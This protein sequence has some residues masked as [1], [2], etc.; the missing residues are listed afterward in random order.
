MYCALLG[1][2]ITLQSDKVLYVVTEPVIPLETYIQVNE[3][4]TGQNELAI[5]WG[6]HQITVS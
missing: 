6:L 1:H 3:Q 4:K 2:L 5:S